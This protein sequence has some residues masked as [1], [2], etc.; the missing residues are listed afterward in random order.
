MDTDA[1]V[2]DGVALSN[3]E[4]MHVQITMPKDNMHFGNVE[5]RDLHNQNGQLFH[6]ATAMVCRFTSTLCFD[7]SSGCCLLEV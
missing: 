3:P 6:Q 1:F 5:H 4:W 7:C 2:L